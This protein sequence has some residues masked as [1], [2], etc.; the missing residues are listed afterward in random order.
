M[1]EKHEYDGRYEIEL[2]GDTVLVREGTRQW[3]PTEDAID[4]LLDEAEKRLE[5]ANIGNPQRE[6]H[7]SVLHLLRASIG[8]IPTVDHRDDDEE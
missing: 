5:E 7:M 1:I 2:N 4:D 6:A 8:N 3:P